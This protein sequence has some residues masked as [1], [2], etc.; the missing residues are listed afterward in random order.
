MMELAHKDITEQIIGAAFEVHQILGYGFLERVYQRAMQ[1]ELQSR[2]LKSEIETAIK[3]VY[4]NTIVGEYRADLLVED[5]VLVEI[6][7]AK[8][9]NSNDEPQ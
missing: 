8:E 7:V 1:V 2:G 6:K 9:Y 4:K 5:V 3:V